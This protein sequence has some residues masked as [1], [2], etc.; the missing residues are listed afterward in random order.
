VPW[1]RHFVVKLPCHEAASPEDGVVVGRIFFPDAVAPQ[2]RPWMWANGH[3]GEIRRGAC[4]EPTR[5]AAMS[6]A[7]SWRSGK[8]TGF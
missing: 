1:V 8:P 6:F 7:K 3:N 4:Y 2:N 5:E